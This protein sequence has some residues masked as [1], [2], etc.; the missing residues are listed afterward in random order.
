MIQETAISCIRSDDL[1]QF[2]DSVEVDGNVATANISVLVNP[3]VFDRVDVSS[4]GCANGLTPTIGDSDYS[5]DALVDFDIFSQWFV[6]HYAFFEERN[7]DWTSLTAQARAT[8]SANSTDEE[9]FDVMKS[10][11][12]PFNDSHTAIMNGEGV[13]FESRPSA[14]VARLEAEFEQQDTISDVET[15]IQM[16]YLGWI[17]T[18]RGLM[19]DGLNGEVG[20]ATSDFLW[21]RFADNRKVGYMHL[22]N[23]SPDD[24]ESLFIQLEMALL[25]LADCEAIIFD[26]RLNNGGHDAI[27]LRIASYF[28]SQQTLAFRKHAVAGTGYTNITEVYVEPGDPTYLYEGTVIVVLSEETVSAAEIFTLTMSQ[29]QQTKLFGRTTNG[30]LSDSLRRNLPNGWLISLSN[31]VIMTPGGVVP[32]IVG[33][34]PDIPAGS[35]LL[36]LSERTTGM[37]SW[38]AEV[39]DG[40]STTVQVPS[41]SPTIEREEQPNGGTSSGTYCGF[42]VHIFGV[43]PLV[44]LSASFIYI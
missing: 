29:L 1:L 30:A 2:I 34:A 20:G 16:Q 9:L 14:F 5:R 22:F 33:I 27:A 32:E 17:D 11:V 19:V 26:I 35:E 6:E 13:L 24:V 12:D 43:W 10:L 28:A 18:V 39:L 36:P 4:T 15:Y 40:L 3:Y 38:L 7:I 41:A 21:G 37:D 44:L 23:F 31:Q 8:L 25:A 42:N